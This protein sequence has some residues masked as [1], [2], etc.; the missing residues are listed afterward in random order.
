[1]NADPD[2]GLTAITDTTKAQNL[3]SMS[4]PKTGEQAPY[5]VVGQ[6]LVC[7]G[8]AVQLYPDHAI[9]ISCWQTCCMTCWG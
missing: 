1:V 3:V 6:L 2:V 7:G 4:N 8:S 9:A 5:V